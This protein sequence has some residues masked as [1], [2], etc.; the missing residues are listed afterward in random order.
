MSFSKIC[1]K[2]YKILV[3]FLQQM[4]CLAGSCKKSVVFQESSKACIILQEV[5]FWTN[6]EKW[7]NFTFRQQG[8]NHHLFNLTQRRAV[9]RNTCANGI[10]VEK[11]YNISFGWHFKKT[12][13]YNRHIFRLPILLKM[14]FKRMKAFFFKTSSSSYFPIFPNLNIFWFFC[15]NNLTIKVDAFLRNYHLVRILQPNLP[16]LPIFQKPKLRFFMRNFCF[17]RIL[18]QICFNL[19]IKTTNSGHSDIS[20][21]K[22]T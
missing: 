14:P 12:R 7:K 1:A 3:S 4:S 9:L 16:P 11:R 6:L 19:V 17:S 15:K 21:G 18:R 13:G 2:H 22:Q 10:R 8:Q 5:H 20:I